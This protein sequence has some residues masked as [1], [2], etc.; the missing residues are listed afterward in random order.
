MAN[1][2]RFEDGE[3]TGFGVLAE[4][5]D[6]ISVFEGDMF[7]DAR[8]T[9][10]TA[11]LTSVR[12]LA[13]AVPSKIVALWNNSRMGAEKQKIDPPLRPLFFIKTANAYLA[14]GEPI[15]KPAAY[16]GRVIFEAELGIVIGKTCRN[17]PVADAAAYVFGYTCVNDVTAL[18]LIRED[19][20]FPQWTRAKNFDTFAP[21][22]PGIVTGIAPEALAGMAIRAELNGRERQNY[23]VSDLFFSP[24]ELVSLISRDMTLEPGDIISCGTGPGAVPM[25]AGDRIDI[26]IDGIGRLGNDYA[27]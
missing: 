10:R 15:R 27:T 18:Q 4:T 12:L 25:K 11:P 5:G 16:D 21:F 13:P 22:G 26:V 23:P 7:T 8:P 17:V 6:A 2:A 1:W 19:P 9:G 14:P 24:L 3:G 20:S